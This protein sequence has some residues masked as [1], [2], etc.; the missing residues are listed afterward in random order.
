M[1]SSDENHDRQ[2]A[3]A[4]GHQQIFVSELERSYAFFCDIGLQ[5]VFCVDGVAAV[6][7]RGGTHLLL[8]KSTDRKKLDRNVSFDFMIDDEKREALVAFHDDIL[9]KEI[10][11]SEVTVDPSY[12]HF[13]LKVVD[14][15]GREITVC[16][17]HV[18]DGGNWF[19]A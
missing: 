6:D 2:P 13:S 18:V 4:I 16:T 19:P 3:V 1:T 10:K 11:C 14:P 9:R 7:L 8:I 17:R 12:G 15:D 5:P